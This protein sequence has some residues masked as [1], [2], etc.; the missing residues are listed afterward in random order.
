MKTIKTLVVLAVLAGCM[1]VTAKA[2]AADNSTEY[3]I[4]T[5]K[6]PT[7]DPV[8][9]QVKWG[10]NGTWESFKLDAGMSRWHAYPLDNFGLAPKPY[11][12]FDYI[13]NDDQVTWKSYNMKFYSSTNLNADSGKPY[14]FRVSRD[15]S[16]LDLFAE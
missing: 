7:N 14:F 2:T 10:E 1:T 13:L 16:I 12:R 15:G 8:N 9:Y 3:G 4:F 5:V 6:N 11:V